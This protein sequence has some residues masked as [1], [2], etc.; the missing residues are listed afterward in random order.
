MSVLPT[1][2]VSVL[3]RP[4]LRGRDED[5][6]SLRR[7]P[8]GVLWAAVVDGAALRAPIEGAAIPT[9]SE[10]AWLTAAELVAADGTPA[11]A[12]ARANARIRDILS[13]DPAL[14]AA[15]ELAE[16]RPEP[17]VPALEARGAAGAALCDALA[18]EIGDLA[19]FDTRLARLA[20]PASV[21]TVVR[22]DPSRGRVEWAHV[23]DTAL[24]RARPGQRPE[25]LSADG[26]AEPDGA[27]MRAVLE[28]L[29][30]EAPDR[31][32][33][34]VRAAADPA[35]IRL[36]RL[37][38]LAHNA[39]DESGEPARNGCGVLDGLASIG[40]FIRAGVCELAPG[41]L[42][43]LMTDGLSFALRAA[44]ESSPEIARAA[45]EW[46]RALGSADPDALGDALDSLLAADRDA[47][48]YPRWRPRDD[49]TA[50]IIRF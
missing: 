5:A 25:I 45:A 47:R 34:L 12:L 19:P 29:D 48:A 16:R 2:T 49:A 1:A 23:G 36:D 35:V 30:P 6:W 8:E 11:T 15:I 41:E 7:A 50:I 18:R 20:I 38:G 9:V 46:T 13:A 27:V 33:A 4:T 14:A 31:M 40:P 37:G 10:L 44:A 21:A 28:R 43:V 17:L 26:M 39:I 3:D 32:A 42:V 24:V 22:A